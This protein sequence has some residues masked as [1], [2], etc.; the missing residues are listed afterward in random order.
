[1]L[2]V[3]LSNGG[4]R[5]L[6]VSPSHPT[7][8]SASLEILNSATVRGVQV[9]AWRGTGDYHHPLRQAFFSFRLFSAGAAYAAATQWLT[10]TVGADWRQRVRPQQV[11][12]PR[13]RRLSQ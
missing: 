5:M 13:A 4:G 11:V 10:E 9:R 12:R 6:Y 1:M 7:D 2:C 8:L 3:L